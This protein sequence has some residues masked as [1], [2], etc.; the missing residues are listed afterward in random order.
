[1]WRLRDRVVPSHTFTNVRV[2]VGGVDTYKPLWPLLNNNKKYICSQRSNNLYVRAWAIINVD[3]VDIHASSTRCCLPK[4]YQRLSRCAHWSIMFLRSRQTP[5]GM[6]VRLKRSQIQPE[7]VRAV[8][9]WNSS[10]TSPRSIECTNKHTHTYSIYIPHNCVCQVA[11]G[12]ADRERWL[13]Q[14]QSSA[15]L[16]QIYHIGNRMEK[17]LTECSILDLM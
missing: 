6:F 15:F 16:C 2:T 5:G 4:S 12:I 8:R 1:M 17:H 14:G 7:R 3:A 11:V 13:H 9:A 10:G